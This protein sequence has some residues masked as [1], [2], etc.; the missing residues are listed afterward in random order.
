MNTAPLPA[1]AA[2]LLLLLAGCQDQAEAPAPEVE[3]KPAPPPPLT[4]V[5]LPVLTLD[6]PFRWDTELRGLATT[7]LE[8]GLSDLPGVIARVP[9]DAPPPT[10]AVNH[11]RPQR[12]FDATF[13]GTGTA[14]A[15]TLTLTLCQGEAC[16]S[17]AASGPR[18]HPHDMLAALI[19]GAATQ[20]GVEV[21][22][23][24]RAAWATPGSKDTYA[25]LITGRGC[26]SYLGLLP[27]PGQ[28]SDKKA[29]SVLR[30]VFIDPAQPIAQWMWARW[31]TYGVAGGG[32]AA[33]TLRRA[34]LA[35]PTSPLLTA[36]LA[37]VLTLVGKP[38]EAALVWQGLTEQAP[39]DPRWLPPYADVLLTLGR[40]V[41]AKA[42]LARLPDAFH[43]DPVYAELQVRIAEGIGNGDLDPLLARWQETDHKSAEPVRRRIQQRV[44]E[45]KYADAL[46]LVPA[47]RTRAPGPQTDALE[48]ALL[49]ATGQVDAA[50]DRAPED[51]A[52]RLRARGAQE[53]NPAAEPV[54]LT[55][56][57]AALATAD[58]RLW[59]NKPGLSLDAADAA[60]RLDPSA[61]AWAARARALEAAGRAEESVQAWQGAWELDPA[62]DGGPV[63]T[64]RIASTF[65]LE[66]AIEPPLSDEPTIEG[67]AGPNMGMEE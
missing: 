11:P 46:V 14:D 22:D 44:S 24:T 16:E 19:S 26:S 54:G 27:A 10:W 47:L 36:D 4:L 29:N 8:L 38:A 3:V 65:R 28:A 23:A 17:H 21:P 41:E 5:H 60:L 35:R 57:A 33:D 67:R 15:L 66:A 40:P 9:G 12:E 52:A 51:V 56:P 37:T 20:L 2:L 31:Q 42:T 61:D 13:T 34:A 7:E 43:A 48:V 53:A 32:T 30:A 49:T 64:Q 39:Q 59:A 45:G 63:G 1:R 50:A 55:G 62:V 6:A 18:E 25:E 58:A